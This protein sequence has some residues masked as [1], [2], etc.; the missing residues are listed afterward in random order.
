MVVLDDVQTRLIATWSVNPG[1]GTGVAVLPSLPLWRI[2]LCA[3]VLLIVELIM[4][5]L[6]YLGKAFAGVESISIY[7]IL[8]GG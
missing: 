3:S 8:A 2:A 7:K 6:R 1:S 5:A 4:T